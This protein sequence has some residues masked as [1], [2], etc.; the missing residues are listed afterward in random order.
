MWFI[1]LLGSRQ[2]IGDSNEFAIP[3]SGS[4]FIVYTITPLCSGR[5]VG[6][7]KGTG[8]F[9][10]EIGNTNWS[11]NG[12]LENTIFPGGTTGILKHIRLQMQRKK[13][14]IIVPVFNIFPNLIQMVVE[15][16]T[17]L[18]TVRG[19]CGDVFNLAFNAIHYGV[20][21]EFIQYHY[22]E[23][24]TYTDLIDKVYFKWYQSQT[25][26]GG[27]RSGGLEG[28]SRDQR[29][30]DQRGRWTLR[31]V[32]CYGPYYCKGRLKKPS[33]Q[34]SLFHGRIV[35]KLLCS[36]DTSKLDANIVY[37]GGLDLDVLPQVADFLF[38]RHAVCMK[39]VFVF[40][41]FI[42]AGQECT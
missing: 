13:L 37:S 2:W 35:D 5:R 36:V 15:P 6:F 17:N 38:L 29:G 32:E 19:F 24:R 7:W 18:P 11:S 14:R 30:R 1:I 8:E 10:K 34:G 9:V 33:Y 39:S 3:P 27:P 12:V 23:G 40:T 42:H 26:S 25:R 22:E 31:G 21:I 16:R 28:A 20:D 41:S 4:Y